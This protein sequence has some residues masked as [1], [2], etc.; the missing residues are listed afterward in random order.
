MCPTSSAS[1]FASTATSNETHQ[2]VTLDPIPSSRPIRLSPT[3]IPEPS[4][5]PESSMRKRRRN[6]NTV[7]IAKDL[8]R[9]H[10]REKPLGEAPGIRE[11]IIAIIKTS[12]LNTLLIFVPL[13][14]I[15][16]YVKLSNT[17][18]FIFSFLGVVPLAKLLDFATDDL[19]LR[20][21]E[22]L[23]ELLNITLGNAVDFIVAIIA[24]VNCQLQVVQLYLVGSILRNLLLVLGMCFYVGGTR[25]SEQGFGFTAV[26]LDSSLLTLGMIAVALPATFNYDVE[27]TDVFSPLSD[28]QEGHYILSISHSVSVILLFIYLCYIVFQLFSHPYLYDDRRTGVQRSVEHP[29]DVAKKL[30][31]SKRRIPPA[32]DGTRVVGGGL[33]EEEEVE[34][35]EMGLQTA[36]ILLVV[37]AVLV[38]I[39][40]GFLVDSVDGLASSYRISRSFVGLILLPNV[41]NAADNAFVIIRSA[42][43]GSNKSLGA[44]VVSSIQIALFVFPYVHAGHRGVTLTLFRSLIIIVGWVLGK[45]LT[46]LFDPFE[47]IVLFFSVFTIIH[48]VQGGKSNWLKGMILVC[49]YVI[50]AVIFWYY[51]VSDPAG[52]FS[53]CR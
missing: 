7:T 36:I 40:A 8:W 27:D 32:S 38:A 44:P 42:K 34:K 50:I 5:E 21:G 14:W 33:E 41:G 47:S 29:S 49:L 20:L 19:S 1:R 6:W 48:V 31:I 51:P 18:V 17:L 10:K 28:S 52:L 2:L 26:K 45:P 11:S 39:T 12:W 9:R 37:V 43:R 15:F 3:S 24:L 46:L 53:I 35:P 13:S 30:H 16:R 4:T 22:T 23:A 25:F